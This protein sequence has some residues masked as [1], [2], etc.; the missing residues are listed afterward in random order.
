M[1]GD[2]ARVAHRYPMLSLANSYNIADVEDFAARAAKGSTVPFDYCCELKFDGTAICLVYRK[3]KLV[4]ALTRGD[5]A[6]GDDVTANVL[7]IKSIPHTLHGSGIPEDFEIR[8][9]IY[10]PYSAFDR[11][12]R[13]RELSGEAPFANPRNAASGSL[14]LQDSSEVAER[15]LEC[16]LYH[17]LGENLPF[18]THNEALEAAK[19]WGLP[20]SGHRR[21][22][23]NIGEI[24]EFI[25]HWDTERKRLPFPTDGVVIKINALEVQ[26]QLGFTSKCPRWAVAYKFKAEEATTVMKDVV[27]Q[28]SRTGKLTPLAVLEPVDLCGTTV[29]RATL[30]NYGDI[31]KKKVKI[32]SR[33]FIRRSNDV[34]PEILGVAEDYPDSKPVEKPK[35]CPEC[36]SPVREENVFLYCTNDVSCAPQIV[37]KITHFAEKAAMNIEGLSDRT[38]EQLYN[39]LQ[40]KEFSDL[41][42]LTF[43]ELMTLDGFKDKKAQNLLDSIEKSKETTLQRFLY[44]LGIP[45]IGQKAAKELAKKFGTLDAVKSATVEDIQQ[46][47]DFGEIMAKSVVNYFEKPANSEQLRLLEEAGVRFVDSDNSAD[48]SGS[49]AGLRVVLTGT[50]SKFKRSEAQKLIEDRGGEVLSTTSSKVNL[51]VAGEEAGSKLQKALKAG[52]KIVDEAEFESML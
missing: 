2:F 30:N 3:G 16:T 36:G 29:R 11:L 22:C 6:V 47:D 31:L 42:R 49:F 10:M 38:V 41:Y 33:V 23:K 20:I 34:I 19:S 52:I 1:A 37:S 32:G 28:V 24:E 12:C 13:E 46:I 5:G 48:D 50:L 25:N 15:G 43:D 39:D 4:Q 18:T 51:V 40:V 21:V 8:G 44:A 27:W 17:I 35:F 14:K 26:Q 9:E 45:N 7:K